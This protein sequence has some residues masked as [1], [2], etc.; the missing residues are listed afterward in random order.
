M[1]VSSA[2]VFESY[3]CSQLHVFAVHS[4]H[5][6]L[7]TQLQG[8]VTECVSPSMSEQCFVLSTSEMAR[9]CGNLPRDGS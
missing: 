8:G 6:C 4:L 3:V 1:H 7:Y 2:V 9:A 5:V